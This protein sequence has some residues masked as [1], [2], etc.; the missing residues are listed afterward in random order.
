[1][2]Q[3]HAERPRRRRAHDRRVSRLTGAAVPWDGDPVEPLKPLTI[4]NWGVVTRT[5]N[6]YVA[7][8]CGVLCVSGE[9]K[10]HPTRGDTDITTS[11]IV[12]AEGR[13]ITTSSGSV[14]R[15]GEPHPEY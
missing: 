1:L 12:G 6:P 9:I 7:P 8:E 2:G 3:D 5:P 14:Y 15:L 4:E 13:L 11:R 10:D